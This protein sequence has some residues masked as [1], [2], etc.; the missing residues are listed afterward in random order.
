MRV[1]AMLF[2]ASTLSAAAS[3]A[4]AP[5]QCDLMATCKS[6]KSCK[7]LHE[8]PP[9]QFV[10]SFVTTAGVINM[11]VETEWAPPL[12]LRVWQLARLGYWSGAPFYRV[13]SSPSP[14]FVIQ[15]GY[16]GE[17]AGL[18]SCWDEHQTTNV[19]WKPRA[20]G[21]VRGSC[22]FSM[23]AVA[24][25]P[26]N[27]NCTSTQYCA[28]GLSTNIFFNLNNNTRL[29]APGFAP[30]GHLDDAS[31]AVA[32]SLYAGYGECSDLCNPGSKDPFCRGTGAD[33]KGV[34]MEQLLDEGAKYIHSDFPLL[35]SVKALKI[36][37]TSAS[38][39]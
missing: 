13:D 24:S 36:F 5:L 27:P 10:V 22:S 39:E 25:L 17:P 26:G 32:E 31:L 6:F 38:S 18:D 11:T 4:V 28:Q 29:D 12:A 23:G 9:R 34:S 16:K 14:G 15:F 30:F 37:D 19:S 33:C 1:L 7:G 35:D 20:P 21:N 8:P 3:T 2:L